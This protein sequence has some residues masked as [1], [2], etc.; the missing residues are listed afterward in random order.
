MGNDWT[1]IGDWELI[2]TGKND[3]AGIVKFDS[4]VIYNYNYNSMLI[5][6]K[7]GRN[8][9]NLNRFFPLLIVRQF[10]FRVNPPCLKTKELKQ[11]DLLNLGGR[12]ANFLKKRLYAESNL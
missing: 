11:S 12:L 2:N 6:I 4:I 1:V 3:N 7:N 10:P 8:I 9:E 5:N